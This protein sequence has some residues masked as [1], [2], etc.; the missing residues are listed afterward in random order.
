M[1]TAPPQAGL[2][3]AMARLADPDEGISP[4]ELALA[5]R[6][7]SLLL[8]AMRHDITPPGLHYVLVHYDVPFL[9]STN[10]SM[11]VGGQVERPLTIDLDTLRS[12]EPVSLPV[13]LE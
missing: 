12:Y 4:E 1:T 2:P 10:W 8:E 11:T 13:T 3:S 5:G 6:N 9:D 7:H